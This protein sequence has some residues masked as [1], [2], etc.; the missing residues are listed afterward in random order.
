LGICAYYAEEFS[1]YID[2]LPEFI[3]STSPKQYAIAFRNPHPVRKDDGP[4]KDFIR[5][6]TWQTDASGDLEAHVVE[7]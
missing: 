2:S 3:T 5:R 6:D 4:D 1:R 7:Q